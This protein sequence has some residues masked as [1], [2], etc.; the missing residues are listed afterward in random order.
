M[1]MIGCAFFILCADFPR[2]CL[3]WPFVTHT[4]IGTIISYIQIKNN[5]H[6]RRKIYIGKERSLAKKMAGA[7]NRNV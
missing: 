4:N 3:K 5:I 7:R 2:K 6:I 1:I